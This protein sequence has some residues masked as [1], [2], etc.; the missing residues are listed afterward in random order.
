MIFR[1]KERF[2]SERGMAEEIGFH[3]EARAEHWI[4]SGLSR[5][6]A[7]RRARIEFGGVEAYKEC[8]REARGSALWGA[9]RSDFRYAA[10]TLANS[11]GF[12]FPAV[13]TLALGIGASMAIFSVTDAVLLRPLPFR[14]PDRLAL[15]FSQYRR[16][17]SI[18]NLGKMAGGFRG[19]MLDQSA[20]GKAP[21]GQVA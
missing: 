2:D 5:E 16:S 6:E 14:N 9:L 12:A 20:L 19:N 1:G 10:R 18:S 21:Y 13:L 8:C 15:V 3:L 11:R 7:M 4:R 17:R